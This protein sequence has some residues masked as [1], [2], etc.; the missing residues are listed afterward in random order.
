MTKCDPEKLLILL[1]FASTLGIT[2]VCWELNPIRWALSV[3][4]KFVLCLELVSNKSKSVM[5]A[6]AMCKSIKIPVPKEETNF[7]T[8]FVVCYALP[9]VLTIGLSMHAAPEK[10]YPHMSSSWERTAVER[11]TVPNVLDIHIPKSSDS[12]GARHTCQKHHRMTHCVKMF[13]EERLA[14][15]WKYL[16]CTIR[17]MFHVQLEMQDT[18]MWSSKQVTKI[19]HHL[20][21]LKPG[22]LKFA[23]HDTLAR[24]VW[25]WIL[26]RNKRLFCNFFWQHC[27]W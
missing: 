25:R 17:L 7:W 19:H 4:V 10:A 16:C 24:S 26:W 6:Q 13:C 1:D 21:V 18:H 15:C 9:L 11:N 20:P 14:H 5:L 23:E 27:R 22:I 3:S 12:R 2:V 8:F